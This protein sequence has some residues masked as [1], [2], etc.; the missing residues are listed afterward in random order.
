MVTQRF[1]IACAAL[2]APAI[3]V[4]AHHALSAQYNTARPITVKGTVKKVAWMNPHAHLYVY[5]KDGVS[6]VM[7]WDLEMASPNLLFLNG[8]KIDSFRPG[9]RVSVEIYPARDGSDRGYATR[10]K[11][12]SP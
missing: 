4:S 11:L 2:L 6:V 10:V 7:N 8:W 9:D 1:L 3:P 12:T 5:T